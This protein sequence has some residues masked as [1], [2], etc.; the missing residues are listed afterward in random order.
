MK[1]IKI[2]FIFYKI[3]SSIYTFIFGRKSM[4]SINDVLFNLSLRAKGYNNYGS[5]KKTGEKNFI[6]K[7]KNDLQLCLDIG[8]NVGKYTNLLLNDTK[9]KIIAFEPLNEAYEDLK[10]IR[11]SHQDRLEIFNLAIG[12]KNENL[13]L[14]FSDEKSEKASFTSNLEKISFYDFKKNKKIKKKVITLDSFFKNYSNTFLNDRLDLIKIDTEGFELEVI[15]GA[16]ETIKFRRPRFIQIECNWHQL[17]KRH[18][19][20]YISQHLQNYTLFKILPYGQ[21]L[22][23]IDSSRP[24]S[25]I[26]LLSNYVFIRKDISI[27]Y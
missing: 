2:F 24:D 21:D 26:F 7:V 22:L 12:K 8:A 5:F 4:Q 17:F 13:E 18:T 15:E 27:N 20:D 6:N 19:V 16:K 1:P 25:N 10:K 23:K 9:S 11:L 14:N 3:V